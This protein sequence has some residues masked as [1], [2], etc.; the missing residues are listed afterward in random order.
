MELNW[1]YTALFWSIIGLKFYIC[2]YNNESRFISFLRKKYKQINM[3][4]T[5][6]LIIL[7]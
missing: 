1:S 5:K 7:P 6:Y 4:F 3:Y 2:K